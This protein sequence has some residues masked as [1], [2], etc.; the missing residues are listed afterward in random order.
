VLINRIIG[1]YVILFGFQLVT[2]RIGGE[3]WVRLY[4][5]P[6]KSYRQ[7]IAGSFSKLLLSKSVNS[8]SFHYF[9]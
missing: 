7:I 5:F 4:F 6:K 2:R 1:T 9:S 3:G 8:F